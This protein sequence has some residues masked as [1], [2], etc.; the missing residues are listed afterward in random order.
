MRAAG[1]DVNVMPRA[2]VLDDWPL[3]RTLFRIDDGAAFAVNSGA[4]SSAE[5]EDFMAEQQ[6]RSDQG[7]F[8]LT[9]FFVTALET[10]RS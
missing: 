1:F 2:R 3:S 5:A 10:K 4:I 8:A 6:A 7:V 9:V